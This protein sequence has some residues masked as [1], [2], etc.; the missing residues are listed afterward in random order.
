M[1]TSPATDTSATPS[2]PATGRSCASSISAEIAAEKSRSRSSQDE[3]WKTFKL[4][5]ERDG[6]VDKF[7]EASALARLYLYVASDQRRSL[8]AERLDV[9]ELIVALAHVE[10]TAWA[11]DMARSEH[12]KGPY[13][14]LCWEVG[15]RDRY[16]CRVCQS[17]EINSGGGE[18]HHIIPRGAGG[19][20]MDAA[21]V[22]WLCRKHH[23]MVTRAVP[24]WHWRE[25]MGRFFDLIGTSAA[26]VKEMLANAR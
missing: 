1:I 8:K 18:C 6:L 7:L 24:G 21:N 15:Q 4:P 14:D 22:I 17:T 25:V 19:P 5:D 12:D 26:K 3:N 9:F 2:E 20:V 16:R 11:A 13:V 10:L 23:S